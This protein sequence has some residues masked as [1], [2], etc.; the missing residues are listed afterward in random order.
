MLTFRDMWVATLTVGIGCMGACGES[1]ESTG[2]QETDGTAATGSSSEGSST[3]AMPDTD[4]STGEPL[5]PNAPKFYDD[6]LP[7]FVGQCLGCH[8]PGGIGPHDLAEYQTARSLA[9]L[10]ATTTEHRVM[11]PFNA[12][13]GGECNTFDDARWLTDEEIEL[14][15]AWVEGGAQEGDPGTVLPDP[16]ELETLQ[17]EDIVEAK[18]PAGYA[19]VPDDVGALDD[20]QCFLFD[21]QIADAPR[22]LT[23][24]EVVP[25]NPAVLHHIVAFVVDPEE[26][27][28]PGVTNA[29]LMQSLDDASPDQPGWDCYGAA[30]NGVLVK[31]TPITWAPGGGAF[32]FPEGTGIRM[33]PGEVLVIQTHYNIANDQGED[34]S[35]VRMSWADQVEREAVN[36]LLDKFLIGAFNGNPVTIPPGEEGWVFQWDESVAGFGFDDR[37]AQWGEVDILGML[38]HMHEAGQRMQVEIM[39]GEE[40]Q[41][42]LYVDRWD[43]D[44]QQAFMYEQPIRV[45]ATDRIQITCEWNT[46]DRDSPTSPGLGTGAEM[47]LL[48]LYVAQTGS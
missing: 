9:E 30:G 25:G 44:W 12:W 26:G 19:P 14:I 20:Y 40:Q 37:I 29:D 1:T 22:F 23:G 32:N 38:P 13:A 21:P 43:F 41:C 15:A 4:G 48:G 36:V 42:G 45:S 28:L 17:G 31:G 5:D 2:V 46:M 11:P 6:V 16:P 27:A 33:D 8:E 47:C 7:I 18:T 35:T 10:I 3:A 34:Q 39:R 24:F